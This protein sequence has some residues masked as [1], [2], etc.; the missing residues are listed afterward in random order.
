MTPTAR[1]QAIEVLTTE[2]ELSVRR[3]CRVV[4]LA[5]T[6][7]Y[8]PP[9]D[10]AVRDAM[11][12]AG[13]AR[14]HERF[15]AP[16]F[17]QRFLDP[18]FAPESVAAE[19]GLSVEAIRGLAA[20]LADVDAQAGVPIGLLRYH[21]RSKDHLLIEAWRATFRRIHERFEDRFDH[22]SLTISRPHRPQG[23]SCL[24]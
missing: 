16:H 19:C 9:A 2:H 13:R 6:A 23:S 21:F 8:T 1:R 3:A 12:R 24:P 5:R 14:W 20:T 4:G 11:G 18:A 7:W 15:Q 10:P 17:A 22:G